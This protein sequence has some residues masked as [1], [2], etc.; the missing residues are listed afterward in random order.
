MSAAWHLPAL[1]GVTVLIAGLTG[2][3][4]LIAAG[5]GVAAGVL[6]IGVRIV[7][8]IWRAVRREQAAMRDAVTSAAADMTRA[9]R[10]ASARAD[11]VESLIAQGR[12]DDAVI[13]AAPLVAGARGANPGWGTAEAAC[14]ST[15]ALVT[16]FAASGDATAAAAQLEVLVELVDRRDLGVAAGITSLV[17]MR[18]VIDAVLSR[19]WRPLAVRGLDVVA[20]AH[21]YAPELQA[22]RDTAISRVMGALLDADEIDAA[23]AVYQRHVVDARPPVHLDAAVSARLPSS[24]QRS[25]TN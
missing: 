15:I 16:G 14:R 23:R 3:E 8:G 4:P 13:H 22:I 21:R 17:A 25:P 6:A 1:V 9:S 19:G 18:G 2:V 24:T 12:L 11:Q 5:L 20:A 10:D 7:V